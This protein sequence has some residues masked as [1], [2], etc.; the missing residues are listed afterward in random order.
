MPELTYLSLGSNLGDRAANLEAA[1][2][3]LAAFGTVRGV[4]SLYETEPVDVTDQ[5]WFLNC[6]VVL[7]T[8]SAP[9]DL[10]QR[11]LAAEKQLGRPRTRDKGPRTIDIDILFYGDRVVDEPGLKI[12]HPAM[13]QRRF[14]LEPLAEVAPDAVHPLLKKTAR[15]ML[16]AL[17]AGQAVHRLAPNPYGD[18]R[19]PKAGSTGR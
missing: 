19:E 7:E 18:R 9:R 14:V 3:R 16:A 10:L 17:P 12:P 13:Q 15:E 4:S 1:M 11:A 2:E 5:P 8:D 6:V